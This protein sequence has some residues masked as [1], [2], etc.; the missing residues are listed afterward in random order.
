VGSVKFNYGDIIILQTH[1]TKSV[2]KG[3]I[4][5]IIAPKNDSKY[6]VVKIF[7]NDDNWYIKDDEMDL[8]QPAL[9]ANQQQAK[10]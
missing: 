4:G 5:F 6:S 2:Y 9:T 7:G 10:V 3:S 1:Y 8:L